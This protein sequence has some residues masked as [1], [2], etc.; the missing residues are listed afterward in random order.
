[1]NRMRNVPKFLLTV[2]VIAVLSLASS[3]PA[4]AA[5]SVGWLSLTSTVSGCTWTVNVTWAG[6][7]GAKTLEAYLTQTYTGAPLVPAFV[8]VNSKSGTATV[9][10]APL[11]P[12]PS[13]NN[14][15]AW[16]QLLDAH[17]NPIPGSLDFAS[18]SPAYCTAL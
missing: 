15:Y 3:G 11:A 14:F 1:M 13:L 16:A 18:V 10:L 9:T 17:G 12:S 2:L 4:V 8:P 6:F 5:P 7:K